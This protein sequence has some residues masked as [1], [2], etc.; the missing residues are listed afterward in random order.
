MSTEAFD[1]AGNV[2][3]ALA[4]AVTNRVD[5]ASS[6]AAGRSTSSAVGLSALH[7]FLEGATVARIGQVIGLTS[8][9]AVRLIDRLATDGYVRRGGGE[10]GRE[11]SVR[12]TVMGRRAAGRVAAARAEVL[13]DALAVLSPEERETFEALT[14]KVLVA[15]I[16]PAGASRWI[17]R[18]CDTDTCGLETAECPVTRSA[19]AQFG[20]SAEQYRV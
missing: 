5:D 10:D 13:T 2:L 18:F 16:R 4:L 15:L 8:S 19:Q 12:L 20:V 11:T 3:G 17:C 1:R 7:F 9:G 14:S 6:A